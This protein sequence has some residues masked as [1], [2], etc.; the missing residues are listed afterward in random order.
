MH[1][2]PPHFFFNNF[3]PCGCI[4]LEITKINTQFLYQDSKWY[5]AK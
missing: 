3:V 2:I 4:S 5:Q 1:L